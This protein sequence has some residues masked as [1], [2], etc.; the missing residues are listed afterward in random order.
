MF[1]IWSFYKLS[2]SH[3]YKTTPD[4]AEVGPNLFITESSRLEKTFEVIESNR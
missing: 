3:R 4:H 1:N 2:S